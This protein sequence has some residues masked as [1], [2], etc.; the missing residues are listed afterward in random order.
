MSRTVKMSVP[1][2]AAVAAV[3]REGHRMVV[4]SVDEGDEQALADALI[5]AAKEMTC[6]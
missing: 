5:A 3:W 1:H 2:G 4:C 6:D